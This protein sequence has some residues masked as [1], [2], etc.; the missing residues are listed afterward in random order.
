MG[1]RHLGVESVNGRRRVPRPAARRKAFI[2][3]SGS[4]SC[5][6]GCQNGEAKT[7]GLLHRGNQDFAAKALAMPREL[8][9]PTHFKSCSLCR[10][11][12]NEL[13]TPSG[14]LV[15]INE[16]VVN[17]DLCAL[18]V[19]L[20]GHLPRASALKRPA[21]RILA[22]PLA[23]EK[24]EAA[25]ACARYLTAYG[26]VLPGE[27][28]KVINPAAGNFGGD[29]LLGLPALVEQHPEGV[30][31]AFLERVTHPRCQARNRMQGFERC[32]A[33]A[34]G[35][36]LLLLE[37]GL[38]LM[39]CPGKEEHKV[40]LKLAHEGGV[41]INRVDGYCSISG[42]TDIVQASKCRRV[43]VLLPD[44]ISQQ[45]SGDMKCA[46]GQFVL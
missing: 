6:C 12:G 26:S 3:L 29:A 39:R 37:N 46:L 27:A 41:E 15:A 5:F 10:V 22:L 11:I 21:N 42:K 9:V 33:V 19:E 20:E 7:C 17:D 38:R 1:S 30:Q 4:V 40:C 25:A 16:G 44:G 35:R 43:F 14:I 31:V 8:S 24:Q 23:I 32:A 45:V 36:F 28:V 13:P 34:P 2:G 18:S